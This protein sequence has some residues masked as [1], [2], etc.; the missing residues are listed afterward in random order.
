VLSYSVRRIWIEINE[1]LCAEFVRKTRR[2]TL[3][4]M[5]STD[6][7]K[8]LIVGTSIRAP[9]ERSKQAAPAQ[10]RSPTTK[11]AQS[12][13]DRTDVKPV[14]K[15]DDDDVGGDE[16]DNANDNDADEDEQAVDVK[17]SD[18]DDSV[19]SED[20][21]LFAPSTSVTSDADIDEKLQKAASSK[22]RQRSDGGNGATNEL[23]QRDDARLREISALRKRFNIKVYG[24]TVPAPMATFAAMQL[25]SWLMTT[26]HESRITEP[27][28]IQ[29]QAVPIV[30]A[31]EDLIAY[32]E[33]G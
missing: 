29:M 9:K 28:P 24:D 26:L 7:F 5:T 19:A 32:S 4:K 20:I 13:R 21:Q 14:R 6:V 8:R 33:T 27:K 15:A 30:L 23:K 17:T 3:R 11:S 10:S 22:K 12:T 31:R 1:N 25:P 18:D 16:H 2:A